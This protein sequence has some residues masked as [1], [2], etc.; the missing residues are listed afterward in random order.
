MHYPKPYLDIRDSI[1]KGIDHLKQ[2]GVNL[3]VSIFKL[4]S[5]QQTELKYDQ[6]IMSRYRVMDDMFTRCHFKAIKNGA[7]KNFPKW[8]KKK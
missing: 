4:I 5:L 3:N 2:S 8:L 7:S 1:N 6:I